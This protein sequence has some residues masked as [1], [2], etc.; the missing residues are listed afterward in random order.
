MIERVESVSEYPAPVVSSRDG[1]EPATWPAPVLTLVRDAQR[2]GWSVV[3]AYARGRMPHGTTG[4]P[5]AER[6]SF[7]VRFARGTWQGYAV[8][9]ASAWKSIMITGAALPPFGKCGR[10]DLGTW[11]AG[12]EALGPDWYDAIRARLAQQEADRKAR[13]AC[14]KGAH[15]RVI[16]VEGIAGVWCRRCSHGWDRSAEPWRKPKGKGEAL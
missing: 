7:S 13:E 5:L 11:L 6:D 4:K 14:D 9:A 12:P 1:V 15:D 3:K 16:T 2:L 8:Y 10:T